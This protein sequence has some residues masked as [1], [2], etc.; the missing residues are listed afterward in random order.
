MTRTAYADFFE[1]LA[2][3]HVLI[4]HNPAADRVAFAVYDDPAEPLDVAPF[5]LAWADGYVMILENYELTLRGNGSGTHDATYPGAFW[6][7]GLPNDAAGRPLRQVHTEAETIARQ[8]W[9]RILRDQRAD[10]FLPIAGELHQFD[11]RFGL[12]CAPIFYADYTGIRAEF[13]FTQEAS[14]CDEYDPTQWL[15]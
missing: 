1:A 3:A 6:I 15:I 2:A 13:Q 4:R 7:L 5:V 12:R 10:N 14:L 9:A 8:L 11:R